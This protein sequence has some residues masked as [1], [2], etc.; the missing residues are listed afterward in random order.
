MTAATGRLAGRVAIVTGGR[1]GMGRT[2]AEEMAREGAILAIVTKG[3][4]P[5]AEALAGELGPEA[6][7]VEADVTQQ[8]SVD[9]MVAKV[10]GHFGRIDILVNNAGLG[11]PGALETLSEADW[12]AVY[13]VNVKGTFLVSAAVARVMMKQNAG[14]IVNIIAASA[15]RSFPRSGAYGS[16]K[17]AVVSLTQQMAL[18]W[19]PF[20]IRVNG[21]SPGAI[22][23]PDTDWEVKEP[24]LIKE[25]SRLPLKRPGRTIDIA[26][27]V[28]YLASDEAAYVTAQTLA[29]DGGGVATWHLSAYLHDGDR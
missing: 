6:I 10:A 12:D 16:S 2:I 27:A 1:R 21:V 24:W 20:S 17:A 29:V 8:A 13:A 26:K 3:D 25:V 11:R 7:A 22:R 5:G 14:S 23:D 18:E 9:A 15:H 28:T 19:S 4:L